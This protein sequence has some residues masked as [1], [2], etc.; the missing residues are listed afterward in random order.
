MNQR[1]VAIT[2]LGLVSPY[3]GDL[4]DFF[5]RLLAGESA[6]RF[7]HTDDVP[8]P[9]RI[10]FVSCP[11]FSA[12][13]TLGRALAGTMDRFAQ[14]GTAAA[15]SAWEDAGLTRGQF[16]ENRDN[17][18]VAWGT[19]LGGTLAY[20]KGYRELW[21]NGRERV[22]PLSVILGMNNA[23]NAHISIQLGL[24][25][26]SMS[27]TVAC[28]S[29]A[30]AIGEA[31]RRVRSGEA[32]VMLTG[33]SD[34]PQAYGV[35]RAWEA[36]RVMAS[37]D[38]QTSPQACRPFS[39]DR[40]G[41]VLAEGGAALVL[42]D[43]AHAVAR[44]ARIHGELVGYGTS[45]DHSHLVRPEAAGQV[46]ALNAALADGGLTPADID[47]VNAHGTATAEGDPVEVA[48]LR[49]V[50]GERA[51]RLPISATKSMHG[52]QLGAAG[53]IEAIVTVL[54]LRDQAIPPT[55][56]LATLDPACVGV[57]HVRSVR[58]D[59]PLRA[60]LSNSFAFGGSNAVLAFRAP[61]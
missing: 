6:V 58:R 4:P 22:S 10:P 31:F 7:L 37:G 36:L 39:A 28:A 53:A 32:P 43:W 24:G 57:D 48:A 55:A 5:A 30:I 49:A 14:L 47:Y 41:L 52:H 11:G 13:T 19:A 38:E 60:A 45:C 56:H 59:Q 42:E 23:A 33:G 44:G 9:L 26:V 21:Q 34:A 29:S 17:W 51:S 35:A 46:R 15:F 40:T 50:F 3:G 61:A 25:G 16:P 12:E 54:A 20:E 27:H 1:R 2:G 18:G 8:R